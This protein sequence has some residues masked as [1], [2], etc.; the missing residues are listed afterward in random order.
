[1]NNENNDYERF[2]NKYEENTKEILV[3]ST[4]IASG[5]VKFYDAWIASIHF[6]AY[7][8]L[9]TDEVHEQIRCNWY[10]TAQESNTFGTSHPHYFK[11]NSIYHLRVREAKKNIEHERYIANSFEIVEVLELK[12]NNQKL[13]A[14]LQDYLTPIH[15]TDVRLGTCVLSKQYNLFETQADWLGTSITVTL[16]VDP[17]IQT[18]WAKTFDYLHLLLDQQ[19]QLNEE[20]KTFTANELTE[21]A[22]DWAQEEEDKITV[23]VFKKRIS[24]TEICINHDKS[25]QVYINDDDLFYGHCIYVT[26]TIQG[27]K[28]VLN[29]TNIAG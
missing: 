13:L 1:M 7:I 27:T 2:S 25:F 20:L 28:I 18:T 16:E 24:I 4:A 3:L 23:N 10:I 26:G 11:P 15:Y 12:E 5:S 8:E 17:K 19:N 21:L 29:D 14:I 9:N 6:H 22:N